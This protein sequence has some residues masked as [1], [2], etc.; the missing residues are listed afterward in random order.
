MKVFLFGLLAGL[1]IFISIG[2]YIF[3]YERQQENA[4]RLAFHSYMAGCVRGFHLREHGGNVYER[5]K[6]YAT[7]HVSILKDTFNE[8]DRLSK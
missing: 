5:C 6:K 8:V 4:L 2:N 1:I 3:N 7:L